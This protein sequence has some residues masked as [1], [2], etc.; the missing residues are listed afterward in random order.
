MTGTHWYPAMSNSHGSRDPDLTAVGTPLFEDE[1]E[2]VSI[3][4]WMIMWFKRETTWKW[5]LIFD[6]ADKIDDQ[7]ETHS[8]VELIPRG[9]CGC[10]L[11]SSRNRASDGE[12]VSAGCEVEEMNQGNTVNFLLLCSRH[13][14]GQRNEAETLIRVLGYLPLAIE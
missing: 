3:A 10:V 14:E 6:N 11:A 9:E 8:L 5:L 13:D 1:L 4:K 12:L 2:N 7:H